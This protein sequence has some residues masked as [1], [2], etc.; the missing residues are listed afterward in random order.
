MIIP[1][2]R[3][4]TEEKQIL[5]EA[6]ERAVA[7]NRP[8]TEEEILQPAWDAG[9]EIT[10]QMIKQFVLAREATGRTPRLWQTKAYREAEET[11]RC[12]REMMFDPRFK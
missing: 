8:F 7:L 9:Y 2:Y 1:P 5:D 3:F 11:A 6:Y 4:T 12:N 10:P